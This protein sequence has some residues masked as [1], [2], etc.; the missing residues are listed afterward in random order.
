M[1]ASIEQSLSRHRIN[2][3]IEHLLGIA[4]GMLAD[5]HLH[6]MEIKFLSTWLDA[7]T[8]AAQTWPCSALAAR[9]R[10]ALADGHIDDAE[11]THLFNPWPWQAD[12][13][14]ALVWQWLMQANTHLVNSTDARSRMDRIRG[15]TGAQVEAILEAAPA[16]W[17][18]N[19]DC[20]AAGRWWQSESS[21][22]ADQAIQLLIP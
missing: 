11:R 5:G 14:S 6:D 12:S 20:A 9:V 2:T 19:L 10:E 17:R 15:I 3:A 18:D 16:L 4:Q 7:N 13:N 22:R 8:E 1:T 21:N